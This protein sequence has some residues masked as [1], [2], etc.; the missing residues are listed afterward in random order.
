MDFA[1]T[2]GMARSVRRLPF[3]LG[4]LVRRRTAATAVGFIVGL[5]LRPSRLALVRWHGAAAT[6]ETL[7]SL[8]EV[9]GIAL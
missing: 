9:H 1:P 8:I 6:F 3:G 2:S 5:I 7:D 4:L